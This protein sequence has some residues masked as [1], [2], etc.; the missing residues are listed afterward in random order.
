M[1]ILVAGFA[2][3]PGAPANPTEALAGALEG[4]E[5]ARG[6]A[7]AGTA[8]PVEWERSWPALKAAIGERVPRAVMLFGLHAR[9][10]RLRIELTAR[11]ARELG[12]V[13]AAGAF[14][15][16]PAISDGPE[17][18]SVD[19]PL[20]RIAAALRRE[21]IAFEWSQDAG[22]YL[23]NETLYRLAENA[24][25]LDAFGFVHVPVTDALVPVWLE[26]GALPDPCR[27]IPEEG[28]MR[29]AQAILDCL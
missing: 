10:E 25:G 28:L 4:R 24:R 7:I 2:S 19:L 18:L 23:C 6:E 27:T 14:P 21:A 22:R 17:R 12:R 9:I 11:N 13:D 3:F 29:A 20:G 15:P 5:T 16:G 1:T 8:L 26:A